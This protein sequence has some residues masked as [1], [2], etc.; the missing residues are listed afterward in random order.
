MSSLLKRASIV[1]L[2]A[3]ASLGASAEGL[4]GKVSFGYLG[5][6]G[7]SESS[8]VNAA[9]ALSYEQDRWTHN[10]DAAARGAEDS[11]ETTAEAYSLVLKSD[12][13]INDS[14]YL[15]GLLSWDKDK[16]SGYDQQISQAVGY[17]RNL[18]NT[19][20][21]QWNAEIGAGARQSDLRDG[22]SESETILRAATDYT[23][24][25]TETSEFNATLAIEAG[26]ENTASEALLAIKARLIGDLALA[27]SYRVRHNSEV[28]AGSEKRDT[29]TAISL[30]YA[31]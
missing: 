9:T 26:E 28:P 10:F 5:T 29:L 13:A 20:R 23:V 25:L 22:S 12:C 24:A 15:F 19:D 18:I 8:S 31:F 30:E 7:N 21:T 2:V 4:S 6:S 17:G 14:S 27:A 3:S 16:F 11:G 1:A